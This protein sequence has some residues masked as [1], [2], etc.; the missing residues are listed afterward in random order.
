MQPIWQL[1][2]HVQGWYPFKVCWIL[3]TWQGAFSDTEKHIEQWVE[4]EG[5][6]DSKTGCPITYKHC[7]ED[8]HRQDETEKVD[9]GGFATFRLGHKLIL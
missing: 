8:D 2:D 7:G 5:N 3:A 6:D 1:K 4:G 9:V